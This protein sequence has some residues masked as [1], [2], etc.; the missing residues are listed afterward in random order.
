VKVRKK[1]SGAWE[2]RIFDSATGKV[3]ARTFRTKKEAESWRDGQQVSMRLGTYVD[4]ALGRVT[5]AHWWDRYQE[6][7]AWV[8][9]TPATK[10]SAQAR[11]RKHIEPALGRR[12]LASLKRLDVETWVGG[13]MAAG[14]GDATVNA[15][16]RILRKVL[17]TAMDAGVIATNPA[18]GVEVPA[19]PHRKERS[20]RILNPEEIERVTEAVANLAN[21]EEPGRYRALI[22]TLAWCGLRIGEAAG[23]R[24]QDLDLLRGRI[25]VRQAFTLVNGQIIEGQTKNKRAR[26]VTIPRFLREQLARHLEEY[27]PGPSGLVFTG[28]DG[29]PINR[30]NFRARVWLRALRDAGIPKP[31]P[32]VHDLRATAASL[33]AKT[34]ANMLQVRDRLGH[35]SLQVTERYAHL[36]PAQDEALADGLDDL[37]S[38]GSHLVRSWSEPDNVTP[39][40]REA[41]S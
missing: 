23:L 21:L 24:V 38:G 28:P 8:K 37:N 11:Y 5:L 40:Q 2:A 33:A 14:T 12:Q 6:T 30:G 36:F 15:C 13:L 25:H 41:G 7:A 26:V 16:H 29:A 39:L 27:P 17:Q 22:P 20:E 4:P 34:G 9:L 3:R 19:V 18:K 10:D 32:S 31:W 35:S 1:P